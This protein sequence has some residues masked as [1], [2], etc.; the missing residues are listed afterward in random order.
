[1]GS[2]AVRHPSRSSGEEQLVELDEKVLEEIF[3]GLETS[4]QE[5]DVYA[6]LSRAYARHTGHIPSKA[7]LLAGY[8]HLVEQGRLSLDRRIL[9]HLQRKPVRTSSGVAPV[10]VLTKPF[11]CPGECIFCPE[12]RGMP[13]SYL[14][15]E[16]G[17]QRAVQND[18][19]PYRQTLSRIRAFEAIGHDA[20]KVELLILGGTW[21]AYPRSYREWFVKRCFDAMN[22]VDAS[23]LEDAQRINENAAH[24]NVGLVVETRPDTVSVREVIH[25][26]RLGVTKVQVGVQSLDD[27]ILALNKRG[28]TVEDTRRALTLLRAAGFKIVVHWMPNLYG[29]TP[30]SDYEDFLRLWEDPA[31]RPDELKIYPTTLLENTELYELWRA[32]KYEPYPEDVLVDLIARCKTQVPRYCR[33]NRVF[34]DIPTPN[35]VAGTKKTNLRQIVR[36]YMREQDMTCQCIRCRE[37]RHQA[38]DP[39]RVRLEILTYET[40]VGQ[41]H[42]LSYV[43]PDDRIAG[44]LR[45]SLPRSP[46]VVPIDEIKHAAM[47]REV[48]VYGPALHVGKESHGEAQHTGLGR[49]LVEKA[50]DIARDAGFREIAVIAAIGTRNYYRK[51]G[52]E[53]GDLYMLREITH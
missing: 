42:F 43:T 9:R 4:P 10:T 2:I 33:I 19:D 46:E 24:R 47:I 25:M 53:L 39:A 34:R 44:F 6:R 12:A 14:P 48:H 7:E 37:V 51:L 30:E 15:D 50:V 17:A 23:S 38:V 49:R 45:L 22:G 11:P 8:R 13:K 31:L 5:G 20:G 3:R 21:A 36:A 40:S 32:G 1:M 16:P 41:E 28:H 27:R 26:R 29:A 18:F 35:I 52:F